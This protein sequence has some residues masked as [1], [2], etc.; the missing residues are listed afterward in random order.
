MERLVGT[1]SRGVRA[2]KM[3]IRDSPAPSTSSILIPISSM[4]LR[5]D[6]ATSSMIYFPPSSFLVGTSHFFKSVPSVSKIP[7]LTVVPP[8]STP[9]QC[10]PIT[11]S[12]SLQ[13][14]SLIHI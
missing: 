6:A 13:S 1:V 2:P 9:I 4:V 8:T 14:L 7:I 12:P 5:M 3:C 11:I 10:L